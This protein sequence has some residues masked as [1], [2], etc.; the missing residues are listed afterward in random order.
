M[1]V[2]FHIL[3]RFFLFFSPHPHVKHY[4][5]KQNTRGD[6]FLS[7]KHCCATI[8]DLVN[9]HRHN[10]GGLASRLKTS[11]CDRPVPATAGLSHGNI[12]LFCC[13]NLKIFSC[14]VF[15]SI[16][17]ADLGFV[18]IE[19]ATWEIKDWYTRYH[20]LSF[21]C[22]KVICFW[23]TNLRH[24]ICLI[25]RPYKAWYNTI[26]YSTFIAGKMRSTICRIYR[27]HYYIF[28]QITNYFEWVGPR[29]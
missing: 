3:L 22:F 1:F 12:S 5:I 15:F 6:F 25:P 14:G 29:G 19:F 9:Y 11:P 16:F 13:F 26:Q 24:Q 4:H 18:V 8:P 21:H 2:L 10:S 27:T 7:E 28:W 17:N 20:I 23:K